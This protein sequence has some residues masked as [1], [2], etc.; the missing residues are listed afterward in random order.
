MLVGPPKNYFIFNAMLWY[1]V[2]S[3]VLAGKWSAVKLNTPW[4]AGILID[5]FSITAL[6]YHNIFVS[7]SFGSDNNIDGWGEEEVLEGVLF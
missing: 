4:S 6:P 2:M 5:V 3:H 7:I 1:M